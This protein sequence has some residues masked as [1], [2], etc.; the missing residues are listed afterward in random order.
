MKTIGSLPLF[1]VFITA[2]FALVFFAGVAVF[3]VA[4]ASGFDTEAGQGAMRVA[5]P[6]L[7][8][9]AL[10]L[11]AMFVFRLRRSANRSGQ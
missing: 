7:A 8:T 1:Q 11:Q 2:L 10:G 5:T 9:G 6:I 3:G 4:V